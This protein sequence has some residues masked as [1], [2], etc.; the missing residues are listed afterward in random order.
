MAAAAV[1]Y[2]ILALLGMLM[3]YRGGSKG[4]PWLGIVG[5]ILATFCT[6]ALLVIVFFYSLRLVGA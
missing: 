6:I 2:L 5:I 4:I 3:A 1:F